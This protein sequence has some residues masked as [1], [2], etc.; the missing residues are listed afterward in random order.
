MIF[1]LKRV[2]QGLLDLHMGHH[3]R[4]MHGQQMLK[5][6]STIMGVTYRLHVEMLSA[7]QMEAFC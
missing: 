6:V 2:R 3:G 5:N 1:I 4:A 7:L